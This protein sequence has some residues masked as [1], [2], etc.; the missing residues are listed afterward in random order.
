MDPNWPPVPPSG[1]G[2]PPQAIPPGQQQPVFAVPPIQPEHA[3]YKEEFAFLLDDG[4]NLDFMGQTTV[5]TAEGDERKKEDQKLKNREYTR[6]SVP[7]CVSSYWVR[8]VGQDG[9]KRDES[10]YLWS[11][12]AP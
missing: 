11:I 3:P 1:A 8:K 6:R 10:A 2:M 12:C 5:P 9:I 7:V 4:G